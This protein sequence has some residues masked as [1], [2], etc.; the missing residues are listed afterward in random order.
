MD[1]LN[2]HKVYQ[3]QHGRVLDEDDGGPVKDAIT[4]GL[5]SL[6]A[7]T[8]NPLSDYNEAFQLLQR[9]RKIIPVSAQ[10]ASKSYVRY[11]VSNDSDPEAINTDSET[12][13]NMGTIPAIP[14]HGLDKHGL[15]SQ[16]EPVIDS[17]E[18]DDTIQEEEVIT[19]MARIIEDIENGVLDDTLAILGAE[20]VDLDMDEIYVQQDDSWSDTSSE[21]SVDGE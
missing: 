13:T 5:Q 3:I 8:K 19:E 20:D 11:D 17:Q 9:R 12:Q 21:G 6:T 16:S 2:E 14:S 7:G 15:R 1:S 18:E 4:T 10:A